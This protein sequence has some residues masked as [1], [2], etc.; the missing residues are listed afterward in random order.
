MNPLTQ[1]KKISILPLLVALA[2]VALAL[3]TVAR[4][5]AVTDWN[6]IASTAIVGD[7]GPAAATR[8]AAALRWCRGRYTTRSTRSTA[9][10]A[11]SRRSRRESDG[12]KEAAAATAAFRV[13]VGS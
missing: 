12:L 13:L 11:V 9:A 1:F 6:A 8:G 7:A 2:L 5:D 4:A 3:P 10:T